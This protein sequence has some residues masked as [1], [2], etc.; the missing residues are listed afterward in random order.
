VEGAK[1]V[2][3]C[4]KGDQLLDEEIAK[5]YKGKKI[6]KGALILPSAAVD[7]SRPCGSSGACFIK[8]RY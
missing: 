5:V 6:A 2:E 4:Q 3:I 8:L 1:I 7:R